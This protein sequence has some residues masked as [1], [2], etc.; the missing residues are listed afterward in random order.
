MAQKSFLKR[1]D[2]KNYKYVHGVF[3]IYYK[4]FVWC[5]LSIL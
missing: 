2:T 3:I 1:K 4:Y 5:I